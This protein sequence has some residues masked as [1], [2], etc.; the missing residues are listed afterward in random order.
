MRRTLG[1]IVLVLI[2]IAGVFLARRTSF[3]DLPAVGS[4]APDFTLADQDGKPVSLKDYRGQWVVLFFYPS[5]AGRRGREGTSS[6]QRDIGKFQDMHSVV[7]GISKDDIST[8]RTFASQQ[9]LQ[10]PV[11][12]DV[13]RRVTEQYGSFHRTHLV[14][15][16]VVYS[17]IIIDPKGRVASVLADFDM[18]DPSSNVLD[19][20]S[21][22]Q[23]P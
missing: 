3:P 21:A 20:L 17:T 14:F 8:H 12:S 1:F 15:K 2:V 6:F 16:F 23:H 4:S 10:F 11:L 22:L 9:H 13:G 5:D 19:T 18:P 7:I